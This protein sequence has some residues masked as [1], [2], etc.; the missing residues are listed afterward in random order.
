MHLDDWT[1]NIKTLWS[2]AEKTHKRKED[3]GGDLDGRKTS[4][5][6]SSI[7]NQGNRNE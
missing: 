1:A 3:G 4:K 2:S 7:S 6:N 5:E